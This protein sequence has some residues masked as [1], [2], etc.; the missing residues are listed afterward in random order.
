MIK[1]LTGRSGSADRGTVP[2]GFTEPWGITIDTLVIA[3][4]NPM[5]GDDGVG[6]V[7]ASRVEAQR[8]AR[9]NKPHRFIITHQLLPE[10]AL[11]LAQA[12]QAI[13]IDARVAEGETPGVVRVEAVTPDR[14]LDE[15]G[16]TGKDTR[17]GLTHH[18]T[19]PRLLAVAD[20]LYGRAPRAY[21]VS[22]SA[23][24]FDHGDTLTPAVMAAVPTM[25]HAVRRLLGTLRV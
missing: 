13:L 20:A 12:K 25:C 3:C 11:D 23:E 7:V 10:H 15:L 17:A 18:W 9:A 22:V 16:Q 24:D 14:L 5:R 1:S 6:P 4:G 8:S 19:C 21:A 2:S